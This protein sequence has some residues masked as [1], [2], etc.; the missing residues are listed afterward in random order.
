LREAVQ[1]WE[2]ALRLVP[3]DRRTNRLLNFGRRRLAERTTPPPIRAHHDTLESPIPGYLA[4]LTTVETGERGGE[5]H[6]EIPEDGEWSQIDTRRV[7][8]VMDELAAREGDSRGAAD[9]WRELPIQDE[10]LLASARGLVDECQ[11]GLRESRGDA[12]AMA[13][14]MALQ[15]GEQS[16]STGICAIIEPMRPLFERA[17]CACIGDM[18]N[19]PIRAI[20]SEDLANHGFDN[21]AAFLMSRMDGN[22][23]VADLLEMAGMPRFDALRLIAAMKRAQAV[24]MVPPMG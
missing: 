22:I 5:I 7:L 3:Q 18:K 14:E 16:R 20:P 8:G 23:N 12:A 2:S 11:T 13:A 10:K 19:A 17:F 1:A 4:S 6:Q 21:R 9:T 24:D 15:L